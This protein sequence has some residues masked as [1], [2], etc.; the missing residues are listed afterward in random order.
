M[1]I[2]KAMVGAVLWKPI[3]LEQNHYSLQW[4]YGSIATFATTCKDAT[5]AVW[6]DFF[7]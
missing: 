7:S 3:N 4:R 6:L 5:R 2:L 1:H